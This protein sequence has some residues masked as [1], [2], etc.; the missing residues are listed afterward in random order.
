M[1]LAAPLLV[2]A[3]PVAGVCA[4]RGQ[5]PPGAEETATGGSVMTG[6]DEA[7]S[8]PCHG[9]GSRERVNWSPLAGWLCAAC[10]WSWTEGHFRRQPVTVLPDRGPDPDELPA[11]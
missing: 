7:P 3:L 5:A 11:A 4:L 6:D 10:Q 2:P 9:C 8:E 1:R